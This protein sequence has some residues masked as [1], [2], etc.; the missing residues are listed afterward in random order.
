MR[1]RIVADAPHHYS[2]VFIEYT[3]GL[4]LKANDVVLVSNPIPFDGGDLQLVTACDI[5]KVHAWL[6]TGSSCP[7]TAL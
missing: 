6:V 4:H 2:G 3:C 7:I 5:P 1:V